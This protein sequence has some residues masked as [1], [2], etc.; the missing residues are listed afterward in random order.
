MT[1]IFLLYI[2]LVIWVRFLIMSD[3]MMTTA[4][5]VCGSHFLSRVACGGNDERKE[6]SFGGADEGWRG[7][8]HFMHL[9]CCHS[10]IYS[11]QF[12][13]D[14]FGTLLDKI[15]QGMRNISWWTSDNSR[16]ARCIAIEGSEWDW[17][18]L[19][20]A[21][22]KAAE[23]SES[24]H[25]IILAALDKMKGLSRIIIIIMLVSTLGY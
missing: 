7:Q 17:T 14:S 12:N 3:C 25:K 22:E 10:A 23:S 13:F 18:E 24:R 5:L 9:Y 15:C 16:H 21:L 20:E 4:N 2:S 19:E 1:L 6:S 11:E 8:L